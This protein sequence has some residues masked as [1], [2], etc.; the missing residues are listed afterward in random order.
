MDIVTVVGGGLAGSECAFQL[1][2]RGLSVR[3]LEQKPAQRT[4]AQHGDGLAELVCSNSF[5]GAALV[6]AVGLLK[7]ELR[8]AGSLVMSVGEETRVPA[9]G[10]F[11]VD[12]ERFSAEITRRIHAHPRIEV[13]TQ[14]LTELPREG[15]VVLATGPLTSDALASDLERVVGQAGVAYYD[16]IAPIVSYDS[17]DMTK[18]FRASRYDRGGDDAYLNA[19]FDEAGY[20]AF[21]Q[22]LID[23]QKVP[24][25]DFEEPCY[26]EGCLP[27]EVIAER[28][29]ETL[30]HGCMKPVG[31]TDPNSSERPYAVVQL[32]A[33]DDPPTAYNLVGFQTRMT[34]PEQRRVF[35][36]IPGLENAE[37]LRLGT[38]HRNTFVRAPWVLDE[39]MRLKAMPNVRL[40][41]QITGVE[42]YIESAASG[43][44]VGLDLARE[45]SGEP[46]CPPP[47]E[48]AL[49]ALQR[50]TQKEV[51]D[52]QPSN[53]V[54]SMFPKMPGRRMRR[55]I[56]RERLAQRALDALGEWLPSV[57]ITPRIGEPL[58]PP[59][60]TSVDNAG[61]SEAVR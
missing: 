25:R 31:L 59:R 44:V 15:H 42:G 23:A 13:V 6:N 46:K 19:A 24:A 40:A 58:V 33:E 55:R 22:A 4:P 10:A 9:G 56:R 60:P 48:C 5:R 54:W 14:E 30:A 21:V 49:G 39:S 2:E 50:H 61:S 47:A 38:L 20:H 27:V 1:A 34:W 36:M 45:L 29:P 18:V 51:P 12:R 57:G 11:A 28:G 17:L 37:F 7:E 26:F 35:R 8:R 16:A 52:Y 3:L 41:G 53:V 32:R 43:F